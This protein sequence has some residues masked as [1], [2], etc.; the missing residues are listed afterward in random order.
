ME[1][2]MKTRW[3]VIIG[4]GVILAAALLG[5]FGPWLFGAASGGSAYG[6]MMG[7]GM[8]GSYGMMGS[9]G[10]LGMLTMLLFWVGVIALVV[11]GLINLFPARQASV[12]PDALEILKRRYARGEISR[13]EFAQARDALQ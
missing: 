2:I 10:W 3:I 8:M 5:V 12:E 1:V 11:W 6:G 7:P 9:F 4:G 13:E